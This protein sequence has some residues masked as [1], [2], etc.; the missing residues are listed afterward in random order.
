[1]KWVF[2][3]VGLMASFIGRAQ[4]DEL[5]AYLAS[6]QVV[7]SKKDNK[8]QQGPTFSRFIDNKMRS[9]NL[10]VLGEGNHNLSINTQMLGLLQK[11]FSNRGL[12]YCFLE[13]GRGSCLMGE[14]LAH[15]PSPDA[16][17]QKYNPYMTAPTPM[18]AL[19]KS[20]FFDRFAKYEY[21]G[22][23]FE[24]AWTFYPA[25]T[26]LL[27]KLDRKKAVE[28]CELVP[29]L[30][31][32]NV[33]EDPV[34]FKNKYRKLQ[35]SFLKYS[36]KLKIFLG[37]EDYEDLK[38]LVSNPNIST[39]NE[40]RDRY[41][42]QNLL[43]EIK[44]VERGSSYLLM[45]GFLHASTNVDGSLVQ[46]LSISKELQNKIL[47]MNVYCDSCAI[48]RQALTDYGYMTAETLESF[49]SA[50]KSDIVVF[51]L[52]ELPDKYSGLKK[53]GELLLY[54]RNQD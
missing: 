29:E 48:Q 12:R 14:D 1:M 21:V 50:A 4:D 6:H 7:I 8:L 33:S 22:I 9:K 5:R 49:R 35:A 18:T 47:V 36:E 23:D 44:P 42:A 53:H 3:I 19:V 51:D 39:P 54:A 40:Q 31:Q 28:L 52:S 30:K 20:G 46:R 24:R 25:I 43:E 17:Q 37:E 32:M 15:V 45:T 16:K 41:M 27:A 26:S 10:F 34:T 2:V 13:D 38:Y 11:H